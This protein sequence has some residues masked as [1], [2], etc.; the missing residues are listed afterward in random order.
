[1]RK[2]SLVGSALAILVVVGAGAYLAYRAMQWLHQPLATI[3]VPTMYEIPLGASIAAVAQ[4]LQRHGIL[5]HPHWFAL[6]ARYQGK[7]RS[8]KA[9]EYQ[10]QPSLTPAQLLELFVSGQVFL[11][12]ITFIEGT[13]FT[14]IMHLLAT[15][16]AVKQRLPKASPEEV[17]A[18]LGAPGV[19]AEGQFFPDTYKFP[20]GTSDENILAIAHRRLQQELQAAWDARAPDLPLENA[21]E[22]LALASI[23]E[24]ESALESER[25]L[26]AGVF[27]ARLRQGMRLQTDPTVIYGMAENY[28]GN[29]RRADLERDTPFNTYTRVGLPPTPICLPSAGSLRAA[30]QPNVTG[31]LYFV[32]TGNGA[33]HYFSHSL[34]EHNAAVKR[35]L[36]QLKARD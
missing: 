34:A 3:S 12:G 5:E 14:D 17:M 10:L 28:D 2:A 18:A 36:A 27:V 26:I 31:A 23:V 35:Y 7:S 22:A 11:H 8:M 21:Q 13:R 29:I 15:N 19:P 6:W 4:D 20:R 30:A 25:P 24:K 1:M 32:A 9:G 33:S 16:P